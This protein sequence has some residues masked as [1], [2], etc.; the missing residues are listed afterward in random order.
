MTPYPALLTPFTSW[1]PHFTKSHSSPF[2][3]TRLTPSMA[4]AQA[5]P[6]FANATNDAAAFFLPPLYWI[7]THNSPFTSFLRPQSRSNSPNNF[8]EGLKSWVVE[9][10]CVAFIN[11]NKINYSGLLKKIWLLIYLHKVIDLTIMY[12]CLF[13]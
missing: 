5:S 1:I 10:D 3:L 8:R 2:R 12:S 7:R 4:S 9:Y 6:I 11:G 13:Q